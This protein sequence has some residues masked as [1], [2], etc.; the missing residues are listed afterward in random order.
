MGRAM[1]LFVVL[2]TTIFA[3]VLTSVYRNIGGVPEVLIKNQLHKEAESVS[4]FVLRDAVRG[5]NS[6][7]FLE[8]MMEIAGEQSGFDMQFT[9][10][11]GVPE[12]SEA[13]VEPAW[14]IGNC[15]VETITYTY[16]MNED[17]YKVQTRI[18]GE[19]Q[20]VEI[21][22]DAEM[23][24]SY[25]MT[26][27][28]KVEPNIVYLE[29]EQMLLLPWLRDI[30]YRLFGI[31]KN[32]FPDSS[33]NNYNG[34]FHGFTFWSPTGVDDT[35]ID[36]GEIDSWDGNY[37]KR[38]L[39]LNGLDHRVTINRKILEDQDED[40]KDIDTNHAFTL[41]TFAKIDKTGRYRTGWF[42]SVSEDHRDRQGTLMWI[43]TDPIEYSKGQAGYNEKMW[44]KPAAGI[45]FERKGSGKNDN[46]PKG[47]FYFY[48]TQDLAPGQTEHQYLQIKYEKDLHAEVYEYDAG[49]LG[50]GLFGGWKVSNKHKHY[51][52]NS[53]AMTYQIT[54]NKAEL[55]AYI[56]GKEVARTSNNNPVRAYP[57]EYGMTLGARDLRKIENNKVVN[58]ANGDA[59]RKHLFGI[60]DQSG[61]NDEAFTPTDVGLWH[62]QVMKSTLM[63]YIRD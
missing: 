11:Y 39:K 15:E 51:A 36:D 6:K 40:F 35:K 9:V 12:G 4:D 10:Y 32:D 5:A 28:G 21:F 24:F 52:W 56:D 38:Y 63:H 45:W 50:L 53:Y 34:E 33:P 54:G 1:L 20:G 16:H 22:R 60:M 29:F 25:P 61:M 18:R 58:L 17:N 31:E 27:L 49:F 44:E 8:T 23:A 42:G 59:K 14:K 2:M 3:S 26:V 47:H 13:L 57:S 37:S 7:D 19:M 62:E 46:L 43:P 48:V 41:M 55:I 30:L